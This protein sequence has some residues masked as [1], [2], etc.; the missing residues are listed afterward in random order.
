MRFWN[1]LFEEIFM[2]K[3][4]GMANDFSEELIPGKRPYD[5]Y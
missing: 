5:R 3:F 2:V 1:V 4:W